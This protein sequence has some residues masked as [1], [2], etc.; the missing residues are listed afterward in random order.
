ML[1]YQVIFMITQILMSADNISTLTCP[2]NFHEGEGETLTTKVVMV[3][4]L[5]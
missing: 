3:I 4:W 1:E 2:L 5:L